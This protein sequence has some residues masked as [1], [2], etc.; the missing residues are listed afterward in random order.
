MKECVEKTCEENSVIDNSETGEKIIDTSP[1]SGYNSSITDSV[2]N[3]SNSDNE[4]A[5]D[6]EEELLINLNTPEDDRLP[7]WEN[8][9]IVENAEVS[10]NLYFSR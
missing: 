9:S 5:P 2:E 3:T 6:V 10:T 4:K 7:T 8:I 1:S